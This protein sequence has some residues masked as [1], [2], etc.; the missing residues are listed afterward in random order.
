MNNI[1]QI[2][3]SPLALDISSKK[4]CFQIDN[5]AKFLQI[6]NESD[7][8][9]FLFLSEINDELTGVRVEKGKA[10]SICICFILR[11]QLMEGPLESMRIALVSKRLEL[12]AIITNDVEKQ[13]FLVRNKDSEVEI[14]F[15]KVIRMRYEFNLHITES[16]GKYNRGSHSINSCCCDKDLPNCVS[17]QYT[18]YPLFEY[19]FVSDVELIYM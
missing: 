17:Y 9:V 10:Y 5:R 13:R 3:K 8:D 12:T 15:K 19:E 4:Y 11:E 1:E 2:K 18:A 7:Q 16:F 6:Y 14:D